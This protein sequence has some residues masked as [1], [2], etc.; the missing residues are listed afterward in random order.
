MAEDSARRPAARVFGIAVTDCQDVRASSRALCGAD[1]GA[2]ARQSLGAY[3][4]PARELEARAA[5]LGRL[6]PG[7]QDRARAASTA[8][9]RASGSA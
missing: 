5:E 3:D 4:R 9:L 7:H 2:A 8:V 1:R 6:I